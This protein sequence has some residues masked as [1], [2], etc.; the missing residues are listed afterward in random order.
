MAIRTTMEAIE[1]LPIF[2][3]AQAR[4]R[5]AAEAC[6]E[7]AERGGFDTESAKAEV[8]AALRQSVRP[9]TGEELVDHCLRVGLVPHDAR[10]FGSVFGTLAR[11]GLIE[12]VGFADRRKGHGTAGARLWRASH[13][14]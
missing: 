8:L 2:A 6:T 12:A 5:A 14:R 9:M 7:K 13:G 1:G 3:A 11:R 10:A 4:G